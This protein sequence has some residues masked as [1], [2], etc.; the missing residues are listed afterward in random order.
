M[1][2]TLTREWVAVRLRCSGCRHEREC[3]VRVSLQVPTPLRCG[4]PGAPISLPAGSVGSDY[5]C[6]SCGRDWR[7]GS[8][9]LQRLVEDAVRDGWG[10]H[11]R[12]GAVVLEL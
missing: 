6:P 7:I 11:V 3:C 12:A 1:P 8:S 4:P 9:D 10:P 2:T 5:R